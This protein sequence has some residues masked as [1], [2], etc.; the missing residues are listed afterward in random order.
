MLIVGAARSTQLASGKRKRYISCILLSFPSE[1]YLAFHASSG[2]KRRNGVRVNNAT[3]PHN[4]IV[5]LILDT[6]LHET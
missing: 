4:W 5:E 6:R 1:G 2:T 3:L